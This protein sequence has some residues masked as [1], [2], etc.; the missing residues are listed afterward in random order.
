MCEIDIG[1]AAQSLDLRGW[2][3][4]RGQDFTS[5]HGADHAA[6]TD[7]A[8]RFGTPS[9]RDA[10]QA[11]WEVRPRPGRG[12]GTFSERAGPAPF[13]TDAQYRARPEDLV[14]LFVVRPAADGGATL[15]LGRADA[16]AGLGRRPHGDLVAAALRRPRWAWTV[17]EA[18]RSAPGETSPPAAVLPGDGT[19]RWRA[20]NLAPR[21]DPFQRWAAAEFA[22]CLRT[23]PGSRR[24]RHAPGGVIIVDNR[25]V[26]HARNPFQDPRRLVLR[27]RLWAR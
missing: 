15:L 4:L 5:G 12:H 10:G 9:A 21:L 25:R 7:I 13:H 20:D 23:A 8:R 6:V 1:R 18:F 26:L 16:E 17:P 22:A 19:L 2:A 24:I 11:V 3:V 14:C 27:V